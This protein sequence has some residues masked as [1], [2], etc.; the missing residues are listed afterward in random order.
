[1]IEAYA[2]VFAMIGVQ[3]GMAIGGAL[4]DRRFARM[5]DM[6][7]LHLASEREF[8]SKTAAHSQ[9]QYAQFMKLSD[10][11]LAETLAKRHWMKRAVKAERRLEEHRMGYG[12]HEALHGMHRAV[13]TLDIAAEERRGISHGGKYTASDVRNSIEVAAENRAFAHENGQGVP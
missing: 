3:L 7:R 6:W 8:N 2:V 5:S 4:E 12:Q 11:T 1:M 9:F 10:I 13:R